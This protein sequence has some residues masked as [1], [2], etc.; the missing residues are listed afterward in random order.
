MVC[1]RCGTESR[2]VEHRW[3]EWDYKADGACDLVRTCGRCEQNESQLKHVWGEPHY[4]HT[5]AC[6][7]AAVC[8]RCGDQEER[9]AAHRF[10]D[11]PYQNQDDCKQI[12][13]CSRC[14]QL[15]HAARVQHDWH[16]WTSS[17]FYQSRVR[18]CRHCGEMLVDAPGTPVSMQAIESAVD[19]VAASG[20]W[21]EMR[22]HLHADE[23]TLLS[24][25]TEK[26][27]K[28]ALER[29]PKDASVQQPLAD[30]Q[31][32]V[33]RCREVGIDPAIDDF[34]GVAVAEPT[35]PAQVPQTHRS[36]VRR[37]HRRPPPGGLTIA[38]RALRSIDRC[39]AAGSAW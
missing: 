9:A 26:Y 39:R 19:R 38:Y 14:G 24:P 1:G 23:A 16:D 36:P 34:G 13:A 3:G 5:D 37:Q 22:R 20:S 7:Q 29:Y 2:R 8:S 25:V 10:D 33:T 27:F 28:L 4:K 12:E 18:V 35:P 21:D 31:R 11:W 6:E 17:A 32:I 30:V 15:G